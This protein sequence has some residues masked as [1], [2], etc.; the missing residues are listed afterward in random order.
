MNNPAEIPQSKI[1]KLLFADT[2]TAWL[3]LPIRIYV[4]WQWLQA[5]MAKIQNPLWTGDQS[6]EAVTKFLTKALEKSSGN[7]PDVS[8]WYAYFIE[9]IALKHTEIL[10]YLVTY[11]ELLVGIAL[12]LGAFTGLASFFGIFMNTNYLFAGAVSSN[13]LLLLLQIGL[14]FAW[15]TAGYIGL[16]RFIL[17]YINKKMPKTPLGLDE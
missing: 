9:H 10:S 1:S 13:P 4:G 16:D 11:G 15:R 17:V 12:I 8:S 3:W 7:H 14:L 2:R 6:G 5:G